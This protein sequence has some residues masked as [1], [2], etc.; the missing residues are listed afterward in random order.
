MAK[1]NKKNKKKEKIRKVRYYGLNITLQ[2][3]DRKGP[4]IYAELIRSIY[5]NR[6]VF[7]IGQE[8]N[9][10]LRTQFSTNFTY[11]R[12]TFE[13]IYGKLLRFNSIKNWYNQKQAIFQDY[14]LPP[15]I[16]PNAFETDYMFIPEIHKFFIRYNNRINIYQ[17]MVFIGKSLHELTVTG[18]KYNVNLLSSNDKIDRILNAQVIKSLDVE[19]SYTNDD[20]GNEAQELIDKMLKEA[21]SGESK[22]ILKPDGAGSLNP[23]SELV[24]GFVGIA[25]DNGKA[26]AKIVNQN[27]R[28][29]TIKTD[30]YPRK[31]NLEVKDVDGTI[32]DEKAVL[33]K[34]MMEEYR[35]SKTKNGE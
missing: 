21:R 3:E 25:K 14:E 20:I 2:S 31:I 10:V 13:V 6:Y 35:S 8:I 1:Q 7:T 34:D 30:D 33:F 22:I 28:N 16:V 5:Q 29:E 4:P 12:K 24:K 17:T 26:S 15:D 18:E 32:G 27:G 19:I 9:M 23:D 11:K